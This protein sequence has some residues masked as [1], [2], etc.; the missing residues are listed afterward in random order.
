MHKQISDRKVAANQSNARKSTGPKTVAGKARASLNSFKH[1][2]PKR[3]PLQQTR[4]WRA[5]TN[6][7]PR[8]MEPARRRRLAQNRAKT[9]KRTHLVVWNQQLS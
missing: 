2:T 3:R 9:V 5:C 1:P 7:S 8:G 6:P 4:A